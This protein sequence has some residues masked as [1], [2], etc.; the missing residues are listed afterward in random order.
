VKFL[1]LASQIKPSPEAKF[2]L[3]A[4]ALSIGQSA[5]N[6]APA[7]KSCE[8]SKLAESSLTEAEINLVG[9]GSVAP[10]AAKDVS[11]LRR[12]LSRTLRIR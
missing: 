8:L 11:R 7:A 6:D 9:G 12:E 5:A 1:T 2:L 10:D 3:G 4:S